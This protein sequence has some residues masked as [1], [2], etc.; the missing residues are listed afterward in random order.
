MARQLRLL[1]QTPPA[2]PEI[3]GLALVIFEF[4]TNKVALTNLN[5]RQRARTA[6][7][8]LANAGSRSEVIGWDAPRVSITARVHVPTW[9]ANQIPSILDLKADAH[10]LYPMNAWFT[11]GNL[12]T[13]RT[14]GY[15]RIPRWRYIIED[16]DDGTISNIDGAVWRAEYQ[17]EFVGAQPLPPAPSAPPP[18]PP[19][20]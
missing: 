16:I 14:E 1:A 2:A 8:P 5:V 11:A 15:T 6:T 18:N 19:G 7:I 20:G 10:L 9:A 12:V 17:L 4:D 3:A 13:F